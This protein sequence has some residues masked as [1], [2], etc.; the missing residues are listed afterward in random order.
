[1]DGASQKQTG[2]AML[3]WQESPNRSAPGGLL[4]AEDHA[5]RGTAGDQ[6]AGFVF[7]IA[8]DH[9]DRLAAFYDFGGSQKLFLKDWPEEINLQFEGSEG[10]AIFEAGG[11]SHAHG[12]VGDVAEHAAVQR[13]HG[14][15][16]FFAGLKFEGDFAIFKVESYGTE[17][18]QLG[19]GRRRKLSADPFFGPFDVHAHRDYLRWLE[20]IVGV[21]RG[22]T[23]TGDAGNFAPGA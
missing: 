11:E 2:L 16:V 6:R 18:D 19:N 7:D 5:G 1:M 13:A 10:F 23:V 21:N 4:T 17:A 14:I 9:A 12:E 15:G 20:V 22:G 3:T 8:F